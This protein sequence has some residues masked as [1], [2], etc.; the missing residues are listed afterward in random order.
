VRQRG[1]LVHSSDQRDAALFWEDGAL[2]AVVRLGSGD[3]ELLQ[4][5]RIDGAAGDLDAIGPGS[6]GSLDL[7]PTRGGPILLSGETGRAWHRT[8]GAWLDAYQVPDFDP[9]EGTGAELASG[10]VLMVW[11]R[12]GDA[13]REQFA[14]WLE[15]RSGRWESGGDLTPVGWIGPD[16]QLAAAGDRAAEIFIGE[17]TGDRIAGLGMLDANGAPLA[18]DCPL[19]AERLW[20][21]DPDIACGAGWCAAVWVEADS[22]SDPGFTLRII[23][24]PAEP[25]RLC[26]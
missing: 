17:E 20:G 7:V 23:Q 8:S 18:G 19:P 25:A 9:E 24:V 3:E 21:N 10:R 26:P 11:T 13:G 14:G 12:P 16:P 1:G 6:F 4:T 15:H 5:V 2:H 22:G